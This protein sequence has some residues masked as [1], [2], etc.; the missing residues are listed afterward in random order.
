MGSSRTAR[1]RDRRLSLKGE[2][3]APTTPLP[4][5]SPGE[6][7]LEE[8][9]KPL[10]ISQNALARALGVSPRRINQIVNG[11][12]AITTGTALR[13]ARYFSTTPEFWINLQTRYDLVLERE[14]L[15]DKLS[16]I[17][18]RERVNC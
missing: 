10:G 11:K 1:R 13:L 6:I 8:F 12:R 16:R 5:T 14:N 7:L 3:M 17:V 15:G 9:M 18:P 4:P 2:T